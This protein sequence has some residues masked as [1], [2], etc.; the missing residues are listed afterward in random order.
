MTTI[1][2]QNGPS[3]VTGRGKNSE[4]TST[5]EASNLDWRCFEYLQNDKKNLPALLLF[6]EN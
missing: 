3:T 4:P 2:T 5:A 6:S 1:F